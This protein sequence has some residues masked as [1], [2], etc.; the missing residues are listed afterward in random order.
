MVNVHGAATLLLLIISLSTWGCG[1]RTAQRWETLGLPVRR[2]AHRLRS[3]VVALAK[4]LD[5]WVEIAPGQV[6]DAQSSKQSRN[7]SRFEHRILIA[8]ADE[9]FPS[10]CP[11]FLS[12]E[13]YEVRTALDGFEAL[14]VLRDSLPDLLISALRMPYL[15]DFDLLSV[16]RRRFPSVP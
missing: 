7:G 1:L 15:S 3:A 16:M 11:T 14:D 13:G 10:D 6:S 9:Q 8:D 5:A 12:R 2:P 4:D